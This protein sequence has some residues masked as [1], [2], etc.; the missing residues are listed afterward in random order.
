MKQ[1]KN[2]K[3]RIIKMSTGKSGKWSKFV[4]KSKEKENEKKIIKMSRKKSDE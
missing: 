4:A 3:K 2:S 1:E